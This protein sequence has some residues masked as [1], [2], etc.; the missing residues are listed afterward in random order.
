M[1]GL[2]RL[3]RFL[4]LATIVG[5]PRLLGRF[6]LRVVKY[7]PDCSGDMWRGRRCFLCA[8]R[9]LVRFWRGLFK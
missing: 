3:G 7:C 5:L 2:P 4:L 1:V 6:L 8:F 9:R